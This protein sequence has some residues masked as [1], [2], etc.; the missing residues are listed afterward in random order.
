MISIVA[1][2]LGAPIAYGAGAMACGNFIHSGVFA[3][4][5]A[6]LVVPVGSVVPRQSA[7]SIGGG[8]KGVLNTP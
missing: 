1:I 3:L 8:Y 2:V 5:Y 7:S 4:I 6:Y